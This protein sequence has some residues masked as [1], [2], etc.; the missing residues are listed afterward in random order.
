[1]NSQ[2]APSAAA[3]GLEAVNSRWAASAAV[4]GTRRVVR[5]G[6]VFR[7]KVSLEGSATHGRDAYSGPLRSQ[8]SPLQAS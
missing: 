8:T 4:A 7:S 1:M 6:S 2:R 3:A 5:S